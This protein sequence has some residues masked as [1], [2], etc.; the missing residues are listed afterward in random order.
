MLTITHAHADGTLIDGTARGDGTAEVL[1]ANGWRWSRNLGAWYLP[2]SRDR[3]PTMWKI[4]RTAT[5]LRNAGHTVE[6][7]IDTTSRPTAEVEAEKAA[8]AQERA[9]AL[10]AKAERRDGQAAAAQARS[11]RADASLPWGGEPIKVGHHSEHR[12]RRALEKAHQAMS[13]SV[14]AD[15]EATEA[16]RRA[17]VA[18]TATD[19]RNSPHTVARRID[20]LEV[21]HRDVT[22]KAE[23]YPGSAEHYRSR[24][25]ELAD[26]IAY[27]KEVREQQQVARIATNFGPHNVAKGDA[28]KVRSAWRR[29]AR[30][31]AKSVS[32][33]TGYTWTDRY[34]WHEIQE[35]RPATP[36]TTE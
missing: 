3:L 36:V 7:A 9:E 32:L 5:A 10:A 33:E 6:L 17:Q 31:N 11:D 24:A 14:E 13:A 28:V 4:D 19:R 1:K 23:R 20:R 21:E 8:R 26:Q 35:H 18:A 25:R 30:T 12:H 34:P 16:D 22:R 29:V 27:W 15:R 2:N